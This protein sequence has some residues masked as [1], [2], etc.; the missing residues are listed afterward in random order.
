MAYGIWAEA[1]ASRGES[2]ISSGRNSRSPIPTG[3]T[4]LTILLAVP[5]NCIQNCCSAWWIGGRQE[6][7]A[8]HQGN[9]ANFSGV[10]MDIQPPHQPIHTWRDFLLHILTITIGLFIA[11]TLE[12]SIESI[13]HRHLVRDARV[14]LRREM[15]AN[16]RLYANNDRDLLLNREQLARDIDQLRELRDGKKLDDANLSWR[17]NWI[18][19][20]ESAWNTAQESGAVSYMDPSWISTYSSVY[21]QQQYIN[22]TAL[23]ILSEESRAGASLEV[24][25]TPSKL[26]ATENEALLIKS[27]EIDQSFATLQTTT[28]KALADLYAQALKAP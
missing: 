3:R 6:D 14:N 2:P 21:A 12:A 1:L 16:Q 15:E 28:M 18:S 19:Y 17:W 13:H 4:C 11:L 5:D 10:Q 20:S 23:A 24:A 7:P 27:A 26:T 8:R 25:R 9:S 22:A